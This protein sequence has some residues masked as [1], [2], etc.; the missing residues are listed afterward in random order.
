MTD[1]A[2]LK[3]LT[4]VSPNQAKLA[5]WRMSMAEYDFQTEDR[6][7]KQLVVPDTLSR[8]PL[9]CPSDELEAL[10]VP[11][12]KSLLFSLLPSVSIYQ[13]IHPH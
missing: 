11:P 5:R 9:P 13:Y 4:S 2:N 12:K 10:I 7:G 1:H 3:W 8:A 6:P